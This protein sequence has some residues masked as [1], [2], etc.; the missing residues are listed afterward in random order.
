MHLPLN[1][2]LLTASPAMDS[3][4]THSRAWCSPNQHCEGF[5]NQNQISIS[6]KRVS[7]SRGSRSKRT[8]E[9]GAL[10]INILKD[11]E[12]LKSGAFT[13]MTTVWRALHSGPNLKAKFWQFAETSQ[14]KMPS[15]K[16]Q[17]FELKPH[18]DKKREQCLKLQARGA[19]V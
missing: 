7:S 12:I 1:L 14:I 3:K 16:L 5:W 4:S 9:L 13:Q 6:Q 18:F 19:D 11:S 15:I 2:Y 10:P 8:A 17:L